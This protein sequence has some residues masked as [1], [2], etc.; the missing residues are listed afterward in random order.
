MT[1]DINV[2]VF[3]RNTVSDEVDV[4]SSGR[5]FHGFGPTKAN[6]WLSERGNLCNFILSKLSHY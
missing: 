5:L 2:I 1:A 3:L 6:D 4:M